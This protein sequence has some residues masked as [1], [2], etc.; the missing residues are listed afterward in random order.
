M[1]AVA[2]TTFVSELNRLANGGATYPSLPA[3]LTAKLAA[4]VWAG[5]SNLELLAALNA[6]AGT[7]GLGLAQVCNVLGGTTNRTAI[8][9]LRARAS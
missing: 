3:F 7:T 9:A 4:N 5:T 8:D 2:N 1:A 6:K